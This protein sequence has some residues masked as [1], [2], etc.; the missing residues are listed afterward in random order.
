MNEEAKTE[1]LQVMIEPSLAEKIADYRFD[2]RI[3]TRSEAARLLIEKGLK[4]EKAETAHT[5]PAE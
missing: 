1:R 4:N 5:I 3:E 2:N